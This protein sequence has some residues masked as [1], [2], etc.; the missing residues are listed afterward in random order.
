MLKSA[1][2]CCGKE[3]DA[4]VWR[5]RLLCACLASVGAMKVLVA[6]SV[7]EL[8]GGRE[9]VCCSKVE[10]KGGHYIRIPP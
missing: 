7:R 2:I 3:A 5:S 9:E 4:P 1:E 8:R 6:M 10:A